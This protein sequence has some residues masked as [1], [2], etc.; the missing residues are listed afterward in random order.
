MSVSLFFL[1]LSFFSY[2]LSPSPPHF[3][4]LARSYPPELSGTFQDYISL[5]IILVSSPLT[6]LFSF[7]SIG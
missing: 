4:F 3:T 5:E 7:L 6:I 2:P 1:P